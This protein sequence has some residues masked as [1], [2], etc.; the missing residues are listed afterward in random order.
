MGLEESRRWVEGPKESKTVFQLPANRIE[1]SLW[2][3]RLVSVGSMVCISLLLV[4]G[5]T[6]CQEREAY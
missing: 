6:C 4:C 5:S 1:N 2:V 3:L